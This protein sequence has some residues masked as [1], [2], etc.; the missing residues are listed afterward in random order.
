MSCSTDPWS[1]YS[2]VFHDW[3]PYGYETFPVNYVARPKDRPQLEPWL[4]RWLPGLLWLPQQR[5]SL[6]N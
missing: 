3:T 6:L 4:R 2:Q 1:F 5:Y